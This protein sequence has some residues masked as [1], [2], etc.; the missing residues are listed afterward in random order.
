MII[1]LIMLITRF[2]I[3]S[4]IFS[5]KIKSNEQN[6]KE[7]MEKIYDSDN[8]LY[9]EII[10]YFPNINY[11]NNTKY[12]NIEYDNTEQ[13]LKDELLLCIKHSNDKTYDYLLE[14]IIS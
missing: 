6:D 2:C 3:T 14:K 12:Y 13:I 7:F 9:A 10:E 1:D 5:K 11:Q 8:S 4:D